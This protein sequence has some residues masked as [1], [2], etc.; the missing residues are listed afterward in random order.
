MYSSRR[1]LY[2][3][4]IPQHDRS[5]YYAS[6]PTPPRGNAPPSPRYAQSDLDPLEAYPWTRE[7]TAMTEEQHR[8]NGYEENQAE[9]G[10]SRK[11]PRQQSHQTEEDHDSQQQMYFPH[12]M[13]I[14]PSLFG[15]DARNDF[16]RTIGDFIMNTCRGQN[17]VE[18]GPTSTDCPDGRLRSS[19]E[20]SPLQ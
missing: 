9:A 3:S 5:P 19:L 4:Y 2:M 14:A 17:D 18:V 11:R 6:L 15:I 13:D 1:L 16:T 10:P 20:H 8:H 12:P 7:G